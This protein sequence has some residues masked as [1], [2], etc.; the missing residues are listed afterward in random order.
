MFSF[1]IPLLFAAFTWGNIWKFSFFSSD[2]RV[3]F[4]D[5][6]VGSL[7]L[8]TLV[9]TKST[10]FKLFKKSPLVHAVI[11]FFVIGLISLLISG[12]SYGLTALVVGAFYL[13]RWLAYSLFFVYFLRFSHGQLE[14]IIIFFSVLIVAMG[15]LQYLF[16]P[17]IRALQIAE[18]DPHYFR[19][20]GSLLDPGFMGIMLVLVLLYFTQK[21]Q[22]FAPYSLIIWLTAYLAFA[23]TYS[24]SSYLAFVAGMAA[25]AYYKKSWKLILSMVAL[26]AF[27]LLVLPRSPDGEGVKLERTSSIIARLDNWKRSL[28]IISDHPVIGVG[29]NTYRYAQRSYGIADDSKWLKS[30]A[31][32]GADSSLLFATATSGL[33]GLLIYLWYLRSLKRL[34]SKNYGLKV[35]LAALIIHSC[36]L[37][38]LFYPYVMLWV[39]LLVALEIRR[40]KS[41]GV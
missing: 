25:I 15:I 20:V 39:S 34:S 11:G 12:S 4:L 41:Q 5:L 2:V 36:F 27:T 21:F 17:D 33:A 24:R 29:F 28:A 7:V 14:K 16:F 23:F 13:L 26:L 30:H 18:W 38:S 1:L 40:Q 35:T 22:R 31:G 8:L 10:L 37:N 9:A 19:V 6:C 3:S 32:A